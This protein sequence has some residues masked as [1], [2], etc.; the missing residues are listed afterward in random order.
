MAGRNIQRSARNASG[1]PGTADGGEVEGGLPSLLVQG[2]VAAIVACVGE[3]VCAPIYAS[4]AHLAIVPWAMVA[5]LLAVA[6]TY[7]V[8]FALL[9]AADSLSHGVKNPKAVPF[10]YGGVGLFGFGAWGVFVLPAIIDSLAEPQG[11]AGL[12][13]GNVA[14]TGFNCAVIGFVAFFVARVVYP[15]LA[16]RRAAVFAMV[17]LTVLFAALGLFFIVRMYGVLY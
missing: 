6:Y 10:V 12:S 9:W 13:A 17:A 5:C 14:A 7:I 11:L 2:V 8:G 1:E 4:L 16:A 15:R 3:F